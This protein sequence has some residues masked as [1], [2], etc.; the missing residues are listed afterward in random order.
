MQQEI[1]DRAA[2][3]FGRQFYRSLSVGAPVDA[4]VAEG[5]KAV[6]LA[7][8]SSIEW[9]TPV[10]HMRAPDG[11]LFTVAPESRAARVAEV[12]AEPTGQRP[13]L[14]RRIGLIVAAVLGIA[15]LGVGALK[16]FGKPSPPVLTRLDIKGQHPFSFLPGDSFHVFVVGLS[17]SG[18]EVEDIGQVTWSSNNER[19]AIRDSAGYVRAL[20]PGRATLTAQT[21]DDRATIDVKVLIPAASVRVEPETATVALGKTKTFRATVL[22]ANG[23]F[24]T[25]REVRWSSGNDTVITVGQ[26]GIAEAYA[27]GTT[28]IEAR[29]VGEGKGATAR[30]T[31]T[32]LPE[33]QV[34]FSRMQVGSNYGIL[35]SV[36]NTS[37]RAFPCIRVRFTMNARVLDVEIRDIEPKKTKTFGK[38]LTGAVRPVLLS[39]EEC[40][41]R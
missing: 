5:R 20:S 12:V 19:T 6:S 39:T 32:S 13:G 22:D 28:L 7:L 3:E 16:I 24:L 2:I 33:L 18:E 15:L 23:G 9:A 21:A 27:P 40:A 29:L 37:A 25:D 31:V 26:G 1:S 34:S 30:V 38:S 4:A 35:G 41:G 14:G 8:P 17:A 36:K 11:A 10:L